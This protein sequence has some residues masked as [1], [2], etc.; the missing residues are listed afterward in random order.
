MGAATPTTKQS[1]YLHGAASICRNCGEH[2][3]QHTSQF[4]PEYGYRA[5]VCPAPLVPLMFCRDVN[6]ID[7]HITTGWDKQA[8]CGARPHGPFGWTLGTHSAYFSG[9][10]VCENCKKANAERGAR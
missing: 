8:M 6:D 5:M 7:S 9:V 10:M 1:L 2:D 4:V 3:S